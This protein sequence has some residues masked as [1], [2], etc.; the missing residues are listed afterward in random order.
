[1]VCWSAS[2][3][4]PS[5]LAAARA[6]LA[7]FGTRVILR[8]GNFAEMGAHLDLLGLK[9][10]DGILLDLG[11]SSHQLDTPE[12][13]FSFR[14]EGPAGHAHEPGRGRLRSDRDRHS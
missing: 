9:G 12:R 2:T 8:Q 4:M 11:V 14:E 3:E 5:A 6:N 10:L 13:G 7:D 1:M